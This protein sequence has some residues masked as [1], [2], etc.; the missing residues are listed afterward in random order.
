MSWPIENEDLISQYLHTLHWFSGPILVVTHYWMS[1]MISI[2]SNLSESRRSHISHFICGQIFGIKIFK[3]SI[4]FHGRLVQRAH[5]YCSL[6]HLFQLEMIFI[7][8]ISCLWTIVLGFHQVFFVGIMR[9]L[10][11]VAWTSFVGTLSI[12][13]NLFLPI[14]MRATFSSLLK[15]AT[16]NH[17]ILLQ[18]SL[19]SLHFLSV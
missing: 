19:S 1:G 18:R 14:A 4:C 8:N 11:F 17:R 12:P 9:D 16:L 5:N 10:G 7:L 15:T 13:G 2:A 3:I 6:W